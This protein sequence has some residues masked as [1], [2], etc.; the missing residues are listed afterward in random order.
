MLHDTA[1]FA[2]GK[3]TYTNGRKAVVAAEAFS[4]CLITNMRLWL[5]QAAF[6]TQRCYLD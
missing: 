2:E 5:N 3:D 6:I 1:I 4:S